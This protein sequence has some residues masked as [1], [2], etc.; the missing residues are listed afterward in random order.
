MESGNEITEEAK[1]NVNQKKKKIFVAGAT[2]VLGK[3][4]LNSF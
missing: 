2:E 4:L 1:K 3:G